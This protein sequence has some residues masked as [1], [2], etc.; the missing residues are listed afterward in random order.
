MVSGVMMGVFPVPGQFT[1]V[2]VFT[3]AP[4][5]HYVF[6]PYVAYLLPDNSLLLYIQVMR[7]ACS[8]NYTGIL[9][10]LYVGIILLTC[11]CLRA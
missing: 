5:V 3:Q 6:A 8:K 11:T 2:E 10:Y 1:S 4:D 9:Y 7:L